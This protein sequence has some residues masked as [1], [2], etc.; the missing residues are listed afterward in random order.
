MEQTLIAMKENKKIGQEQ[1]LYQFHFMNTKVTVGIFV[2][3]KIST[4]QRGK[5]ILVNSLS[6]VSIII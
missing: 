4:C 1:V 2:L 3:R 5:F 6:Y